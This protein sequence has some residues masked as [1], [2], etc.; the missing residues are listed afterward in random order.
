VRD[1]S[2]RRERVIEELADAVAA[3]RRPHP[4]RVAVDGVGVAGK[5]VLADEMV[6][7]LERRGRHVIRAG[8]DGFHRPRRERYRLGADSPEGYLR[9]SFDHAA[10][11]KSILAPLGPGGSLEYRTAA[12]DFRT[13]APVRSETRAAPSDAILLFDG[14]FLLGP[15]LRGHWDFAI[16]VRAG[17]ETT[18]ERALLRDLPLFGSEEAV[19]RRYRDRYIPGETLYLER[20]RPREL[21]DVV[22]DND[23]P[24]APSLEWR[25]P[26]RAALDPDDSP[27]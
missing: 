16:F 10:V 24:A 2:E 23:D 25:R 21:A 6:V 27:R 15:E 26:S 5:T 18:L 7:P 3:V 11:I 12:F 22:V 4:V 9:D 13:D 17:F 19:R 1:S 14:I 8:I 20:C